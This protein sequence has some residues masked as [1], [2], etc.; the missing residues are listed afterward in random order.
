MII[1]WG[2]RA[3]RTV[4]STGHFF[5]PQCGGD[6]E[7]RQLALRQWF[8]LFFIP[9]IPLKHLG[10]CVECRRCRT[11]FTER[12]LSATT[13]EV[14][15]HHQGL[16]NRA[17]VVSVLAAAPPTDADA[18][19][20]GVGA[21]TGVPGVRPGYDAAALRTDLAAFAEPGAVAQYLQPLAAEMTVEGREELLRRM[22][23]LADR[24][25]ARGPATEAALERIGAGLALSPAHVAG[26]RELVR[27]GAPTPGAEQ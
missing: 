2:W 5:C 11:A 13:L 4:L 1:I 14:F 7:Y 3:V 20:L 9:L 27:R 23:A 12:V 21:L 15:A 25:P 17:A 10:T 22:A 6:T 26:V 18:V 8:T 24:L 19:A 16:A